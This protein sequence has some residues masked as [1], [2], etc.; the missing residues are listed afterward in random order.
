MK[1]RVPDYYD[2]FQCIAGNCKDNCCVGGWEIDIDDETYEYYQS[3]TGDIGERLRSNIIKNEDG[4]YCFRLVDGRCPMLTDEGLCIVH[5]ELGEKYLGVV[6]N[7]FPRYSEYYGTV[8]ESG[9]GMACEEAARIM[10]CKD[11]PF[12]MNVK[13]LK[14][15]Y[16]TDSEYNSEYAAKIFAV[17][18]MIF[19]ILNNDMLS[20]HEKLIII[21]SAGSSVQEAIND[22]NYD[23]IKDI[24]DS[25]TKEYGA[26]LLED[27]RNMYDNG[28]FG[29][30]S[31]HDSIREIFI[32][33]EEMEVLNDK[34]D[35]LFKDMINSL[36]E[37]MNDV[38][39]ELLSDEFATDMQGREY[40]YR[41]ILEYFVFRYFAK[42]IYDYD[43]LGK[44]QMLVTNFLLIR[45]MDMF[46]WLDNHKNYSFDDRMDIMH[47]FSRQVE[48][49]E[50]NIEN[51]YEEYIFDEIYNP[52]SLKA[53]LWLD[54][55]NM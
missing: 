29:N 18:E 12:S 52:D 1:L 27:T 37:Q 39:Y 23:N 54:S 14:E 42:S 17:R 36:F 51:L 44:C 3:L 6:C 9:I 49:S 55:E 31:L 21:L 35:T 46:R 48:Y 32:P 40:E 11:R 10:L 20:I 22:G 2:E 19:H 33:Y 43:V 13:P 45:H 50:E 7:Q 5:K 28:E 25:Y 41:Q 30:I 53:I 16:E 26:E 24:M 15:D 4:D 34:W 8:K 38:E 47:I